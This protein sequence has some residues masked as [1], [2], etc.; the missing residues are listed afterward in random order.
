MFAQFI[1]TSFFS[2]VLYD[3]LGKYYGG[4]LF[5]AIGL[6][7]LPLGTSANET[8]AMLLAGITA[9]SV[10]SRFYYL[11]KGAPKNER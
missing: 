7:I 1:V 4:F 2:K 8:I 11:I 10:I 3:P 6:T 5:G 9:V